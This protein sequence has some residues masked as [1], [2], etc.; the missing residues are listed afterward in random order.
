VAA[1][2]AFTVTTA[3]AGGACVGEAHVITVSGEGTA[4]TWE[5]LELAL[6]SLY[7]DAAAKVAVDLTGVEPVEPAALEVVRRQLPHFRNRGGEV[8]VACRAEPPTGALR[9]ERRID[10]ALASLF[11]NERP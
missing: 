3:T 1:A 4:E 2:Q 11:A 7:D 8:V 6:E 10:D 5:E 9:A